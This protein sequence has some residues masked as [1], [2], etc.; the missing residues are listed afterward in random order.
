MKNMESGLIEPAQGNNLA[1]C[2]WQGDRGA[3]TA[4]VGF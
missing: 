4:S 1:A 3:V 2:R